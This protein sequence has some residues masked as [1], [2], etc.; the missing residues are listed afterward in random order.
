MDTA[1]YATQLLS[2]RP[3]L[4]AIC[5][6]GGLWALAQA[7]YNSRGGVSTGRLSVD[8]GGDALVAVRAKQQARLDALLSSRAAAKPPIRA[9]AASTAAAASIAS[10]SGASAAHAHETAHAPA[11]PAEGKAP[12][13]AS[14]ANSVSAR[15]ARIQKGKGESGSDPLK[16]Y[17]SS[18]SSKLS[19]RKKGG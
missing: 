6:L 18:S 4:V 13:K 5:L 10:S 19:C 9:E 17:N 12:M 11:S 15:L 7:L 8:D 3:L 2:D 14:D 16:G 1:S